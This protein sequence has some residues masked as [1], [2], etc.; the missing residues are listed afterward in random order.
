[1][2]GEGTSGCSHFSPDFD[3]CVESESLSIL[4]RL[5]NWHAV[6][7]ERGLCPVGWHVPGNEEWNNL[8]ELFGGASMA[9]IQLK[10]VTGWDADGHGDNS[11]GFDGLPGGGR[12]YSSPDFAGAGVNGTWWSTSEANGSI[13]WYRLFSDSDSFSAGTYDYGHGTG[14]SIRCIKD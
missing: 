6:D 3:P 4:G 13:T 5:Y 14:F 7:D 10:S 1:M 8:A 2:Y 12:H 11:S 9:G